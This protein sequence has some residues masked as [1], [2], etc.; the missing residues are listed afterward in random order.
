MAI[1]Q[2]EFALLPVESVDQPAIPPQTWPA[3][4]SLNHFAR[5][6]DAILAPILCSAVSSLR[7][8]GSMDGDRIDL[9]TDDRRILEAFIRLDARNVSLNTVR[10]LWLMATRNEL[11]LARP[12]TLLIKPSLTQMIGALVGSEAFLFV[13]GNQH[14]TN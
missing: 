10:Q 2:C 4:I 1:W 3:R 9:I 8:W 11:A 7:Q 13:N 5:E 12:D 6:C 14:E